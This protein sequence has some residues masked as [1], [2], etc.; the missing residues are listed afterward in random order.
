MLSR[1]KSY[2]IQEEEKVR[3]GGMRT[4]G[5]GKWFWLAKA[6]L[7]IASGTSGTLLLLSGT[8][9]HNSASHFMKWFRCMPIPYRWVLLITTEMVRASLTIHV[10][11]KTLTWTEGILRKLRS[12]R[13]GGTE[14]VSPAVPI[15]RFLVRM[16][17]RTP[18]IPIFY[19]VYHTPGNGQYG[20]PRIT[21]RN[22]TK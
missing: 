13:S 2:S 5:E 10:T 8:F 7:I 12:F 3:R 21:R 14:R 11:K 15:E 20:G 16:S 9:Q 19:V 18:A 17:V 1:W 6:T 4:E 22:K